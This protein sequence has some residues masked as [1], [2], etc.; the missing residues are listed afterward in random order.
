VKFDRQTTVVKDERTLVKERLTRAT[1]LQLLANVFLLYIN[2][3][4]KKNV[5]FTTD[6]PYK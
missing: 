4:Q 3:D 1:D 2:R 5:I 6:L